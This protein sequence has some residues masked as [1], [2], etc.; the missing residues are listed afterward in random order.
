MVLFLSKNVVL[1]TVRFNGQEVQPENAETSVLNNRNS[2]YLLSYRLTNREPLE[3]ELVTES[4]AALDF[5]LFDYSYDLLENTDFDLPSRPINTMPMPFVN[6][7]ALI[8][9]QHFNY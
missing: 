8:T 5:T 7:D 9:I 6:T 2:D 4:K 1:N 3:V